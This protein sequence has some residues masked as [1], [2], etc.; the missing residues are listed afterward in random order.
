MLAVA[1]TDP[2]A[3]LADVVDLVR[4]LADTGARIGEALAVSWDDVVLSDD[5]TSTTVHLRGTKTVTSDR[6]LT[7]PPWLSE[8]LA[9]RHALGVDLSRLVFSGPRSGELRDTRNTTRYIRE[10]FRRAGYG[11][12]TPH[13]FRRTVATLIDT[14]LGSIGLAA[15]VLGHADASTTARFYINR[16]SDTSAA[17]AVL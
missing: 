15:N 9:P 5:H 7:L 10:L 16:K 1:S 6:T 14:E 13:S 4:F 17:A 3:L 12:A 2:E 8:A 11:W